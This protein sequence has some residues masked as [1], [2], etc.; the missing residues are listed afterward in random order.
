[1]NN[2]LAVQQP[3]R[4]SAGPNW[5]SA[6]KI[7]DR[8][9][10]N[11]DATLSEILLSQIETA[12]ASTRE[13]LAEPDRS[14]NRI[15]AEKTINRVQANASF[16]ELIS[17]SSCRRADYRHLIKNTGEIALRC[18]ERLGSGVVLGCPNS[19]RTQQNGA[20]ESKHGTHRQNIE[21]QGK[22]HVTSP[23][24]GGN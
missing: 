4:H 2:Q 7:A 15:N 11:R 3:W 17:A 19:K 20:D 23:R 5:R 1:L 21:P 18:L 24:R 14:G 10:A 13:N 9:P 22:V 8:L 16:G 6:G 12:I